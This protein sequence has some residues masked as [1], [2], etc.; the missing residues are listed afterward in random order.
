MIIAGLRVTQH[1]GKIFGDIVQDDQQRVFGR[2]IL[3]GPQNLVLKGF[4]VRVQMEVLRVP[5]TEELKCH[6]HEFFTREFGAGKPL[7]DRFPMLGVQA[8]ALGNARD[9]RAF[10]FE[11]PVGFQFRESCEKF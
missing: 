7:Q 8:F 6:L 9:V 10:Q 2:D 3:L 11:P 1:D 4:L 5:R